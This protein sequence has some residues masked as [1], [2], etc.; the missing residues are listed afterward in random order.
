ML[1]KYKRNLYYYDTRR[2]ITLQ[3][4]IENHPTVAIHLNQQCHLDNTGAAITP[5][6]L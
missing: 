3:I 2:F 5:V 1:L 6:D 4:I